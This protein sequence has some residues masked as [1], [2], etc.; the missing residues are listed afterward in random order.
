MDVS[1][2]YIKKQPHHF[3][4]AVEGRL[5]QTRARFGDSVQVYPCFQQQPGQ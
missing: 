2:T 4:F 3:S 5:V 1:F